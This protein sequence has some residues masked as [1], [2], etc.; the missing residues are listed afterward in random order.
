VDTKRPDS[1]GTRRASFQFRSLSKKL[2]SQYYKG[3]GSRFGAKEMK[4][5]EGRECQL[6]SR[7][8]LLYLN[9]TLSMGPGFDPIIVLRPQLFQLARVGAAVF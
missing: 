7:G 4:F 1:V 3:L 6:F 9:E 8:H 2:S 5:F